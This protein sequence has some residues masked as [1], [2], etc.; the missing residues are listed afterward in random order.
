VLRN[1][2]S[3]LQIPSLTKTYARGLHGPE[4]SLAY[5][6]VLLAL[7]LGLSVTTMP[8]SQGTANAQAQTWHEAERK[9]QQA[10]CPMD[11]TLDNSTFDEFN[12]DVAQQADTLADVSPFEVNSQLG[13]SNHTPANITNVITPSPN[14]TE[15]SRLPTSTDK[16]ACPRCRKRFSTSTNRNRHVQ[17]DCPLLVTAGFRCGNAGCGRISKREDNRNRHE[18]ELCRFRHR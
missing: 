11:T 13:S 17:R 2:E 16:L 7:Y 9:E 4:L 5:N 1:L 8:A 3:G 6:C 10:P 18:R 12:V 14:L 15:T